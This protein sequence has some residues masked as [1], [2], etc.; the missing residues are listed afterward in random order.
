MWWCVDW[1]KW[2]PRQSPSILLSVDNERGLF[3]NKTDLS[4]ELNTW[5]FWFI[6]RS[7][8]HCAEKIRTT[9]AKALFDVQVLGDVWD[10]MKRIIERFVERNKAG[11]NRNGKNEICIVFLEDSAN[12]YVHFVSREDAKD[13]GLVPIGDVE[14]LSCVCF[15][16]QTKFWL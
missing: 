14:L 10:P 4:T 15:H 11:L 6:H 5:N 13:K 3:I 2:K 12:K 16:Q 7:D 1:Y 9:N 8:E